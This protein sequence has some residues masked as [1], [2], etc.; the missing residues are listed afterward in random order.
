[1]FF[2]GMDEKFKSDPGSSKI[3]PLN[4]EVVFGHQFLNQE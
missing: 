1:M 2:A 4:Q 3:Q